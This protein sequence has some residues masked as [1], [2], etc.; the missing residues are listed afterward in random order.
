MTRGGGWR[1]LSRALIADDSELDADQL[2]E[3]SRDELGSA[4]ADL[5]PGRQVTVS[6][7]IRSLETVSR[8]MP[9]MLVA[10]LWDGTAAVLVIWLGR[11]HVPGIGVGRRL[12]VRGRLG[13]R[14]PDKVLYN[15]HYELGAD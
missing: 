1:R 5:V 15:P 8:A 10:E 14:G 12:T 13:R 4:A 6:G 11:R 7:R 3:R 9:G 2:A